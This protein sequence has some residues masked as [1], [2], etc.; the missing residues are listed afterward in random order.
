MMF[1]SVRVLLS[2]VAVHDL[3]LDQMVVA[4]ASLNGELEELPPLLEEV[5]M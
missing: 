5:Y 3:F 1:T 2:V 4:N